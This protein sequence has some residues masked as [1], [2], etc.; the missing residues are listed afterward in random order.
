M[1]YFL[2]MLWSILGSFFY[3]NAQSY[4]TVVTKNLY[5]PI[6]NQL[7][8]NQS[9]ALSGTILSLYLVKT[10]QKYNQLFSEPQIKSLPL[11]DRYVT[12]YV[13]SPQNEQD[14][15]Y[16]ID[17]RLYSPSLVGNLYNKMLIIR[18][19]DQVKRPCILYTHGNGGNLNT[20]FN[21]YMIGV[22]SFL[23]RG[24][25]VA[26]YENYNNSNFSSKS[27]TI[28]VYKDW[29]QQN[30]QDT[31]Q[32]LPIDYVLQRGH[33]LLYQYAYAAQ[34]YLNYIADAYHLDKEMI[35]TA[36]HSAGGL[37]SM[38]LTFADPG[39]NFSHPIFSYCGT[40][41]SRTYSDIPDN[42]IPI[43]GV[44]CS[45]AGL[46]DTDVRGTY[47]GEYFQ[48]EDQDKVVVMLHGAL[49]LLAPVKY[50]PAL[51]GNFVDTVKM[52]GPLTLRTK[53][54]AKNIK[55]F[56][57]INCVGTHGVFSYPFTQNEKSGFFKNFNPTIYDVLNL[58]DNDFISD[59]SLYQI[60]LYQQQMDKMIGNAAAVFNAVYRYRQI[61]N[62]SSTYTWIAEN[63]QDTI[64]QLN[65]NYTPMP[66]YC[67]L[68]DAIIDEFKL[69][70]SP[71]TGFNSICYRRVQIFPNPA[72]DKLSIRGLEAP[73]RYEIYDAIGRM[74]QKGTWNNSDEFISLSRMESGIFILHII[75]E[76]KV[77]AYS[78]TKF[79][80][81][82]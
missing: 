10:A 32:Y 31:T 11:Q 48:E 77:H 16:Q 9:Q 66:L 34:T 41:N 23:D 53:L 75:Q 8:V 61:E 42:R 49:D 59:T 47:F 62:P 39:Q 43:K 68:P 19:Y 51:W 63:Y 64:K 72:F 36:G 40:Y 33:Y 6:N 24:F 30:L 5:A 3:L 29:L 7:S 21:Y 2:S 50:G 81:A 82:R 27:N 28:Q 69:T 35:F 57:F 37:S 17:L 54:D 71:S 12:T 70:T 38:E 78:N 74:R 45:A 76:D 56:S 25:A 58:R 20:W 4:D 13:T 15:L 52:M 80:I 22:T 65:L 73:A 79:L 26:F 46:Q 1:K 18:P 14:T 67:N 55:N 60:N 44:L